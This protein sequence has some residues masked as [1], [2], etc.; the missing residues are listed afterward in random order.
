MHYYK[1]IPTPLEP[2]HRLEFEYP[3]EPSALDGYCGQKDCVTHTLTQNFDNCPQTNS[4]TTLFFLWINYPEGALF[5]RDYID[6][7][8]A[9]KQYAPDHFTVCLYCNHDDFLSEEMRTRLKESDITLKILSQAVPQECKEPASKRVKLDNPS[10]IS[11][12]T[13]FDIVQKALAKL[14]EEEAIKK[15]IIKLVREEVIKKEILTLAGEEDDDEAA[16]CLSHELRELSLN[17]ILNRYFQAGEVGLD[18]DMMR[19]LIMLAS[20]TPTVYM[21]LDIQVRSSEFFTPLLKADAVAAFISNIE[22][23]PLLNNDYMKL[24][25]ELLRA[26][27][28]RILK[29]F[30]MDTAGGCPWEGDV[31][32]ASG[33]FVFMQTMADCLKKDQLASKTWLIPSGVYGENGFAENKQEQT[34]SYTE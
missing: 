9:A 2:W 28:V 17:T 27:I 26:Y 20:D 18:V 1:I 24:S 22:N 10:D 34:W 16:D 31:P 33:P 7:M 5:K 12:F 3:F 6:H 4:P 14:P 13:Y 32:K 15:E 19:L 8:I 21:D 11:P 29:N 30:C 23:Q 25:P